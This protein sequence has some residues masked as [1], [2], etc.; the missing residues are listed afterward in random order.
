MMG[1]P[2]YM[3]PEQIRN[4]KDADYRTD[5]WSLGVI[6]H[7]LVS[8][9]PPFSAAS[10]PG[11][12]AAII[13]DPP[14]RLR[15]K[16]PAAPTALEAALAKCLEKERHLRYAN[17]AELAWA[18]APFGSSE[19]SASAERISQVLDF[20]RRTLTS[21]APRPAEHEG[22]ADTAS[23]WG[24]TRGRKRP[25]LGAG[26]GWA[27][28][29]V[30]VVVGGALVWSAFGRSEAAPSVSTVSPADVRESS[31]VVVRPVPVSAPSPTTEVAA[32]PSE[33]PLPA[34]VP[35]SVV[36]PSTAAPPQLAP[37]AR[38]IAPGLRAGRPAPSTGGPAV[39]PPSA[40]LSAVPPRKD[41]FDDTQ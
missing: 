24:N 7:E 31:P 37:R 22:V 14:A 2:L 40:Q 3:S 1:S 33:N 34:A 26:L 30:T 38:A 35:P 19:S 20:N 4:A 41:L 10:S 27:A 32:R 29:L 17:V 25:T 5:I 12:F 13:A 15:E 39:S 18:L 28:A 21:V 36:A 8:G 11:L 16:L 9:T 6:L 23:A